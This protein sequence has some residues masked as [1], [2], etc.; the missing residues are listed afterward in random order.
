MDKSILIKKYFEEKK[1]VD[2][3]IQSFNNFLEK[4]LQEVV[5]ENKEAEPA[6]I[7]HNIE[8]FKI[9]FG[10]S[11]F[12]GDYPDIRKYHHREIEIF[13]RGLFLALTGKLLSLN[14]DKLNF[15]TGEKLDMLLNI[16]EKWAHKSGGIGLEKPKTLQNKSSDGETPKNPKI[17]K[18]TSLELALAHIDNSDEQLWTNV[19]QALARAYG[20]KGLYYFLK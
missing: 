7:P 9:R 14:L 17:L 3:N 1:F 2:S 4:G 6:I 19:A 18:H 13:S 15:I 12:A 10:P 8:K 16:L 20:E 5:E 11:P